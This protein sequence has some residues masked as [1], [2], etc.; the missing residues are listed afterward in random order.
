MRLLYPCYKIARTTSILDSTF[1]YM[2]YDQRGRTWKVSCR[3]FGESCEVP[4]RNYQLPI[5]LAHNE[6]LNKHK[7]TNI[8][9][10]QDHDEDHWPCIYSC[11][12]ETSWEGGLLWFALVPVCFAMVFRCFLVRQRA[13]GDERVA[14]N[15][16]VALRCA[17]RAL[18][19]GPWRALSCWRQDDF[20]RQMD[21]LIAHRD[22]WGFI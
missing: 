19:P 11:G 3:L 15:Q 7:L 5:T 12:V 4:K 14:R 16:V 2:M 22:L 13:I 9:W 21:R 10:L 18:L 8:I 20:R 1:R 6:A 17:A